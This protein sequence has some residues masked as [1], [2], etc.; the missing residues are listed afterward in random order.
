MLKYFAA[1]G[2]VELGR[3]TVTVTDPEGIRALAGVD[4]GPGGACPV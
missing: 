3:G 2:L 4:D 1:E